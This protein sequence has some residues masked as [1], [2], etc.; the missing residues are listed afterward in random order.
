[1]LDN[2]QAYHGVWA[3]S[4]INKDGR[5]VAT[6]MT[7][8]IVYGRNPMWVVVTIDGKF[9]RYSG[10]KE[11]VRQAFPHLVWRRWMVRWSMLEAK[12]HP[13]PVRLEE[14]SQTYG[15]TT[16]PRNVEYIKFGAQ[17]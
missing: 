15:V 1:M 12:D 2:L 11:Q 9:V 17:K 10:Y 6:H 14:V 7:W 4:T 5:L 13:I 16:P 8:Q 3:L